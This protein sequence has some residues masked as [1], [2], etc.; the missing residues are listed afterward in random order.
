VAVAFVSTVIA[1]PADA[2]WVRLADFTTWHEWIP[3]IASTTMDPGEEA[4]QVGCVR[5]ISLADGNS[6]RERLVSK[7]NARR[8]I[9]YDFPADSPFPVRRYQGKVRVE[10]VTTTGD[11]YVHWSGD[12]DADEAVENTVAEIFRKT[13]TS[14]LHALSVVVGGVTR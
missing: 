13:Y 14:F 8:V 9:T 10:E 2:V 7:D 1:A 5:T 11:T 4:G 12:F 3:R 6:V